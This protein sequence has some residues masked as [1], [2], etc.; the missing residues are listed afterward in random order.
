MLHFLQ[1]PK[2]LVQMPFIHLDAKDS[3]NDGV[4]KLFS[5]SIILSP[6]SFPKRTHYL[7]L[8]GAFENNIHLKTSPSCQTYLGARVYL[9]FDV[10]KTRDD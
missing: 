5:Y 8:V 10:L 9:S 4:S 1:G 6:F 2:C 7:L 3:F